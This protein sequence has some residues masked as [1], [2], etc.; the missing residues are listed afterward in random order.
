MTLGIC[1]VLP[2]MIVWLRNKRKAHETNRR[3]EVILVALEKNAGIGNLDEI[4]RSLTPTQLSF[5]EQ[6]LKRLHIELMLGC[7]SLSFGIAILA[8]LGIAG[9]NAGTWREDIVVP[10]CVFS[11]P[12]LAVGIGLLIA[13]FSGKKIANSPSEQVE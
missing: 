3:T 8:V 7:I 13:Y 1:V 4:I 10:L 6:M 12:S 11:I 2:V 9:W 5:K